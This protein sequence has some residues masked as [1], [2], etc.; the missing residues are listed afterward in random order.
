MSTAPLRSL[1][2]LILDEDSI[3][4]RSNFHLPGKRITI[5]ASSAGAV[6]G[7]LT[8]NDIEGSTGDGDL[9]YGGPEVT[10]QDGC[11]EPTEAGD[12]KDESRK[13]LKKEVSVAASSGGGPAMP[14]GV[15]PH[16]PGPDLP[17]R[18]RISKQV[19]V[20]GRSFG[21]AKPVRRKRKKSKN[22]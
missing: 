5:E 13:S 10:T 7:G 6:T 8:A 4:S 1:I 3:K 9:V 21:G 18:T 2:R 11:D 22:K 12:C 16:Y 14:L 19:D 17:T 20:V 15:G